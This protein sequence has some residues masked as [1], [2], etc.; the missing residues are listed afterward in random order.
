MVATHLYSRHWGGG[1][2][3]V[4][5]AHRLA[6]VGCISVFRVSER[7]YVKIKVDGQLMKTLE[8]FSVLHVHAHE[9]IDYLSSVQEHMGQQGHQGLEGTQL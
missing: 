3:R 4:P 1:H 8:V 5:R 6:C 7:C 9:Y 2:G